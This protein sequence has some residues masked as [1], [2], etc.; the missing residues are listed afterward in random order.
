MTSQSTKLEPTLADAFDVGKRE[1]QKE[2]LLEIK[3]LIS[4]GVGYRELAIYIEARLKT[5]TESG[6]NNPFNKV[7]K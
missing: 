7:D 6:N 4:S 2:T 5:L 3:S 1:G